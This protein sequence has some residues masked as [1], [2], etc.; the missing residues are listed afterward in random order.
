MIVVAIIGIL[1]SIAV[2]NFQKFQR[3]A[4]QTE[5]KGY[6]SAMFTGEK[7]FAAEWNTYT[8]SL[9]GIGFAAEGTG[10]YTA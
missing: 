3:K 4:K 6:L 8:A 9:K 2:P 10:C 5:G 7:S 1:A